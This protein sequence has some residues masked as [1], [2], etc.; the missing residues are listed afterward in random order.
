ML[1]PAFDEE[2]RL[3]AGE[4]YKHEGVKLQLN[5]S[6]TKFEKQDNGKLTV[7]CEPKEGEPYH[8]HDVD[9]VLL[10]TGRKPRTQGLGL[11]EVGLAHPA[12]PDIMPALVIA[13]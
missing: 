12:V 7:R 10:A 1:N 9:Q 3:H 2:C 5:V 6:P 4:Q 11:E 13:W 8:I